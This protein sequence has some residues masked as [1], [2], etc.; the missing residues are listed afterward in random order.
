MPLHPTHI[1]PV[2]SNLD[3]EATIQNHLVLPVQLIQVISL[4]SSSN[5]MK[6]GANSNHL[7]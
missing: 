6:S 4:I 3:S 5:W 1:H 2:M 7:I